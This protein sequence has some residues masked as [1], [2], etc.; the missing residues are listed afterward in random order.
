MTDASSHFRARGALITGLMAGT[1]DAADAVAGARPAVEL[2]GLLV[3][4]DALTQEYLSGRS[5][6]GL[7]V[8]RGDFEPWRR[9]LL[10]V[11]AALLERWIGDDTKAWLAL[12]KRAGSHRGSVVELI[13]S[14]VRPEHADPSSWAGRAPR[15][16]RGVDASAVLL[17]MAPPGIAE[18]FLEDSLT[19]IASRGILTRMLDRGPLHP[20]FLDHALDGPG[21][22]AMRKALARNPA[23]EATLLRERVLRERDDIAVLEDSY[24]APAADRALRIGVVRLADDAG[25]F[26]PGFSARLEP[27]QENV[28]VLEPLLLSGD[29]VLVYWVLRRVNRSVSPAMR[30]T[31]YA[32]LARTAGPEPVWALEKERAGRLKRMAAP[33]RESMSTG[34]VAPILAAAED[35]P[36]SA[37]PPGSVLELGAPLIEPWPYTELIREHVERDWRRLAVVDTLVDNAARDRPSSSVLTR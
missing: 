36:A 13:E 27:Y 31:G 5:P 7:T 16:P 10:A 18:A 6:A 26:R 30:W 34:S 1:L 29:P 14:V 12:A 32:T 21:T 22:D 9:Q 20:L 28:P 2:L 23:V 8:A 17:A 24:L 11:V 15:W 19:D 4:V 37:G 35:A 33:V 25:G 3:P